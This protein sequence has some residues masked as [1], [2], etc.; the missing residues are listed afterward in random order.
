MASDSEFY[1]PEAFCAR[2]Q[3]S[4]CQC[5]SRSPYYPQFV[6][7]RFLFGAF[8]MTK[9]DMLTLLSLRFI[10]KAQSTVKCKNI[11]AELPQQNRGWRKFTNGLSTMM[12][13]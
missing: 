3:L 13:I 7:D 4:R 1:T 10:R 5:H 12:I 8:S 9:L 6:I 11:A 2:E